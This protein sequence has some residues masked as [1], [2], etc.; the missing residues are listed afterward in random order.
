MTIAVCAFMS[1]AMMNIAIIINYGGQFR[2]ISKRRL[3]HKSSV[4]RAVIAISFSLSSRS[5]ALNDIILSLMIINVIMQYA[6]DY[7]CSTKYKR[8]HHNHIH[9]GRLCY[10]ERYVLCQHKHARTAATHK[11]GAQDMSALNYETTSC[12]FVEKNKFFQ[13]IYYSSSPC[14]PWTCNQPQNGNSSYFEYIF[15]SCRSKFADSSDKVKRPFVFVVF[16]HSVFSRIHFQCQRGNCSWDKSL[17]TTAWR[18][19]VELLE[20]RRFAIRKMST[21][22]VDTVL[23]YRAH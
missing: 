19:A 22:T 4:F 6:L 23:V 5:M 7:R 9:N 20:T 18:S 3:R 11:S 12:F 2:W 16:F 21:W 17:G 8:L 1:A 13:N 14:M 10:T 15:L